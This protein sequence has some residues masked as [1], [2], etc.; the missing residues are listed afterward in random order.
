M[1]EIW[2]DILGYEGI[3]QA[4]TY[5]RIKNIADD[6]ILNQC[7]YETRGH[8]FYLRCSL[9]GK[10]ITIHR[11]IALTFISNPENKPE[12]DHIDYDEQN[13]QINNLRWVTK[14]ENQHHSAGRMRNKKIG[15]DH[16][17]AVLTND[18][19]D[20]INRLK[21]GGMRYTEIAHIFNVKANTLHAIAYRERKY[22]K[23][24]KIEGEI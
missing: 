22:Q 3:F 14:K 16:I 8:K 17:R 4:S 5:G 11:L 21:Q 12:V 15:G 9:N 7:K 20:E 13:N 24:D 19:R 18:Q 10:S 6:K 1:D 23:R 2:K